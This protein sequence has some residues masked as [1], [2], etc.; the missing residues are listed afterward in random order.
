VF[1]PLRPKLS[2]LASDRASTT[3]NQRG[4]ARRNENVENGDSKK[5]MDRECQLVAVISAKQS[6]GNDSLGIGLGA[7]EAG[8]RRFMGFLKFSRKLLFGALSVFLFLALEDSG[9]RRK[10]FS[11]PCQS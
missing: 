5:E 8:L 7:I 4:E 10:L 3:L 1:F 6:E 2:Y 11:H 9:G